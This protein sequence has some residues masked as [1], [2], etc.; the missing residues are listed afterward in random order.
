MLGAMVVVAL[1]CLAVIDFIN[2]RYDGKKA[3]VYA[4]SSEIMARAWRRIGRIEW[5]WEKHG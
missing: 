3:K 5:K 4:H 2:W 1:V